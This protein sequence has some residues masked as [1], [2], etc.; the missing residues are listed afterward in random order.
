MH[1]SRVRSG[2]V[3]GEIALAL[4]LL[5]GAGLV[6]QSFAKMMSLDLGIQSEHAVALRLTLPARYVDSAQSPFYRELQQRLS[7]VP[8]VSSVSASDRAPTQAGGVS[9]GIRLIERP[10]A[11]ASRPLMSNVS[12]IIPGYFRTLGMRLIA[13]R[14]ITWN[15]PQ[16]VAIV[17]EAA[18]ARFWPGSAA[19]GKHIG[20]GA[21]A[22]DS[23]F[24]VIGVVSNVRRN[25]DITVTEQPMTYIPLQSAASVVRSMMVIVRSTLTTEAVVNVAKRAVHDVDETLPM[26]DVRTVEAIVDEAMIQP[27]F[28]TMLLAAFAAL[29]LVL[30]IVGIYG[31]VSHS[32][33]QRRQELGVRVALGAQ[34]RDVF[35]LVVREGATL[36]GAGVVI[37]LA[38][39]WFLTPVLRSWLYEVAPG[40]P[41]TFLGVAALLV[42]IALVATAIPAR[43]ATKVDPVIA[44]RAE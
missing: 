1:A 29:A 18:A 35:R 14:D 44:M 16:M 8:G 15:E 36:A 3:I 13:G 21:R 27:R 2:L 33:A 6:L 20:F 30:A 41:I 43:R 4:T 19:I 37:G 28:N 23:G 12:A 26:Y 7:A 17:N 42:T 24:V 39:S 10:E 34:P 11:S 9:T 22:T 38:A 40:D 32:V 31:V 25:D 5:V